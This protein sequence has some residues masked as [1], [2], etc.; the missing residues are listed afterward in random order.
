MLTRR[1]DNLA[2]VVLLP[3]ASKWQLFHTV[4]VE[5][6]MVLVSQNRE[7]AVSLS[8]QLWTHVERLAAERGISVSS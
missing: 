5:P 3:L 2:C 6:T 7:V 8:G 4:A 1:R